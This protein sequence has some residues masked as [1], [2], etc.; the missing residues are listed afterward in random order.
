LAMDAWSKT[1]RTSNIY[2]ISS[3]IQ[4][5]LMTMYLVMA[6]YFI[7]KYLNQPNAS[8][9]VATKN[10]KWFCGALG[11][12]L[13]ANVAI[14]TLYSLYYPTLQYGYITPSISESINNY[15]MIPLWIL[16]IYNMHTLTDCA[17]RN[18][19]CSPIIS[20]LTLAI[21]GFGLMQCYLISNSFRM[22]QRWP[23]DD[24]YFAP[25]PTQTS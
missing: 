19:S 22:V 1:N 3:I 13:I 16:I 17:K 23:T 8:Q 5:S 11:F 15:I 12:L 4:Y 14:I 21:I 2:A 7:V 20:F 18:M 9:S 24:I 25:S 10:L 6:V